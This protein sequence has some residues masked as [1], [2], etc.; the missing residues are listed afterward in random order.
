MNVQDF[1]K[2]YNISRERFATVSGVSKLSINKYASEDST[3]RNSTRRKIEQAINII[4]KHNLV[5]PE[6]ERNYS[7]AWCG[8]YL[9]ENEEKHNRYMETFKALLEREGV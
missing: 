6:M 7:P 3:L 9:K 5:Y 2:R 1:F 4:E 8:R